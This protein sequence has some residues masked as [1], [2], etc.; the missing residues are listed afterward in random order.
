MLFANKTRGF[1][2]GGIK[3]TRQN[4]IKHITEASLFLRLFLFSAAVVIIFYC[5]PFLPG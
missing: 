5:S 1:S 3:A 2:F 4:S